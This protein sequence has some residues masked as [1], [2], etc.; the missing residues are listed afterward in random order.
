MNFPFGLQT[1]SSRVHCFLLHRG[2]GYKHESKKDVAKQKSLFEMHISVALKITAYPISV[3]L[4]L[5]EM[6]KWPSIKNNKNSNVWMRYNYHSC[7]LI[8]KTLLLSSNYTISILGAMTFTSLL[9]FFCAPSISRRSD[10][11]N[12]FHCPLSPRELI[13]VH[14]LSVNERTRIKH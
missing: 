13:V 4:T 5:E 7:S 8:F 6:E 3:P 9:L 1:I 12:T 10:Y 11:V 14:L 2:L